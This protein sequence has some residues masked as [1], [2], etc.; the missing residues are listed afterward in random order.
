MY[1]L[2]NQLRDRIQCYTFFLSHALS[3]LSSTES[4]PLLQQP[5]PPGPV[6][7]DSGLLF[8][9]NLYPFMQIEK[10]LEW[11]NLVFVLP[12]VFALIMLAI[13]MFGDAGSGD[14]D[15][16]LDSHHFEGDGVY[17]AEDVST[18]P[19]VLAKMFSAL[20]VGKVPLSILA[21]CWL[22][23]FGFTGLLLMNFH[24]DNLLLRLPNVLFSGGLAFLVSMV[25][26]AVIARTIG[27][28]LPQMESYGERRQDFIN[29]EAEVRYTVTSNSGTVTMKDKYGN[30]QQL[31]VVLDKSCEG[32][33]PPGSRVVLLSYNA[34][35]EAFSVIPVKQLE[36]I[37]S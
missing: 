21:F 16:E 29:R 10:L 4:G 22:M 25:T 20:G 1:S 32:N 8:R 2:V 30:L 15:H 19:S 12:M 13:S 7:F 35:E 18:D 37:S 11:Q 26:T 17:T 28:F 23:I 6:P 33:I 9:T 5:H 27:R 14:H 24:F 34:A 31:Q 3:V 36:A